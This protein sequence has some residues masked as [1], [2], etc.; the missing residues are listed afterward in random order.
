MMKNILLSIVSLLL[1]SCT[2]SARVIAQDSSLLTGKTEI[3]EC[4]DLVDCKIEAKYFC[5]GKDISYY[6]VDTKYVNGKA[7][8][9]MEVK[10]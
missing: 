1:V 7:I 9:T 8:Y 3:V 4:Y 2:S 5:T 10:C 6:R